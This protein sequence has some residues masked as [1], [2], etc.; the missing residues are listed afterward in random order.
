MENS[1]ILW[2]DGKEITSKKDGKIYKIYS[3][4]LTMEGKTFD[5]SGFKTEGTDTKAGYIK[6][7][8]NEE[9]QPSAPASESPVNSDKF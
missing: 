6:G 4:K 7:R 8:V 9:W 1:F 5:L 2:L 3:G